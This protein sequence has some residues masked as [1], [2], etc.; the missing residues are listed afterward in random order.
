MPAVEDGRRR[1]PRADGD[2]SGVS[3]PGIDVSAA[4][5]SGRAD[6]FSQSVHLQAP[7]PDSI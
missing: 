4:A 7:L 3:S 6:G 1:R 5:A 2:I